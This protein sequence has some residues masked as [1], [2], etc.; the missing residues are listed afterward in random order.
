[1]N[2]KLANVGVL[3]MAVALVVTLIRQWPGT[4]NQALDYVVGYLEVVSA[5][6]GVVLFLGGVVLT[7]RSVDRELEALNGRVFA[8][9]V[10][11]NAS[12]EEE[13]HKA[14]ETATNRIWICQTWFPGHAKDANQIMKAHSP[15]RKILLASFKK[16]S[17]IWA[18]I[19]GRAD[20]VEKPED[21]MRYVR[22]CVAALR[23]NDETVPLK[24]NYGHHPGWIAI[25]DDD[26]FWGP[27]PVNVDNQSRNLFFH[28][29]TIESEWGQFW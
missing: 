28:K 18:R 9:N 15:K 1:M 26:V 22:G 3:M 4:L 25:I 11:V 20:V 7:L 23:D 10:D 12:S 16:N 6:T 14:I 21:A 5:I 17:H 29:A 24:F 2:R 27:T 19:Q 8:V 13:Y